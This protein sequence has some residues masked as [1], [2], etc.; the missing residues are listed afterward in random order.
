MRLPTTTK[1]E[2]LEAFASIILWDDDDWREDIKTSREEVFEDLFEGFSHVEQ[3]IV[4]PQS[5]EELKKARVLAEE[6]RKF[7]RAGNLRG[8]ILTIQEAH[9][10]FRE[11]K[12]K[13]KR[14]SLFK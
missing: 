10:H 5:L 2:M 7:Y 12:V 14:R 3:Q 13:S 8:G 1:A 6:A 4:D 9:E 11:V